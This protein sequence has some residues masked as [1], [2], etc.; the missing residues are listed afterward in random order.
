M[1][2]SGQT[3]QFVGACPERRDGDGNLVKKIN[4]NESRT[5][6]VGA[7][8][9][10][11]APYYVLNDHPSTRPIGQSGRRPGCASV[12]TNN[13]VSIPGEQTVTA[14]NRLIVHPAW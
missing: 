5:L 6:Y 9:I 8:R 12:V 2:D 13:S 4:P 3:A 10:D 1:A 11:N 14:S 7:T